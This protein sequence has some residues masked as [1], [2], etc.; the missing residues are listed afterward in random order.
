[1]ILLLTTVLWVVLMHLPLF[2]AEECEECHDCSEA[3]SLYQAG[4][5]PPS[6]RPLNGSDRGESSGE[7]VRA[8]AR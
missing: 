7:E 1:M 4:A 8:L 3:L 5:L 6:S 2:S